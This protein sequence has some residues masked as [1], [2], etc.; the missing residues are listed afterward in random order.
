MK[1]GNIEDL[2]ILPI[3]RLKEPKDT[4]PLPEVKDLQKDQDLSKIEKSSQ[5]SKSEENLMDQ[6][7]LESPENRVF[8][9]SPK[10][11]TKIVSPPPYERR[12]QFE[13]DGFLDNSNSESKIESS[14][15]VSSPQISSDVDNPLRE[16]EEVKFVGT[17]YLSSP[18]SGKWL[19]IP[20]LDLGSSF[21]KTKK[22]REKA[23][24]IKYDQENSKPGTTVFDNRPFVVHS[25]QY[26]SLLEK[27]LGEIGNID[28]SD[29]EL[30]GIQEE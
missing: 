6:F 27:Q 14:N 8:L 20:T 22:K 15:K 10:E 30:A 29:D 1:N 26:E 18:D 23:N 7:D 28:D 11:E 19:S 24:G 3:S 12:V 17:T 2:K 16:R 25:T 4:E 5:E 9:D 21:K 13:D